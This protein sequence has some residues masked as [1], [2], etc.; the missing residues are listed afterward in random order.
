MRN[1]REY[2]KKLFGLFSVI[3]LLAASCAKD[4][5]YFDATVAD[6]TFQGTTYEYLKSKPGV[7]DSLVSVIDR[8]NLQETL[9]DSN[10]TLFAVTNPSFRLAITNLNNLRRST[11]KLP[12]YLYNVDSVQLDTMASQYIIKGSVTSDQL[13]L[14]DGL[15][16]ESVRTFYPMH[17]KLAK[18]SS[19]GYVDGGPGVIEFSNTNKSKFVRDWVTTSTTANNIKTSNGLIHVISPDHIFGFDQFVSRI[20][21][22]PPPPNL[23][24][25]VGGTLSVSSESSGGPN[26]P[27]ASRRVIDRD[28]FSKFFKGGFEGGW[29][30]FEFKQ[31]VVAGS[32]TITSANDFEGRDPKAWVVEG[33]NDNSAWEFLDSRRDEMFID[34]YMERVF[35]FNNKKAYKFYRITFTTMRSGIDFQIAEWSMNMP[36]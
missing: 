29:L 18:S 3:T 13:S 7:F 35:Y 16:L 11:D 30:K 32:Y 20:T 34:R 14:Q 21:Y 2:M 28:R 23:F 27:E 15:G 5:G 25:L 12:Q 26:G 1:S 6:K 9:N 31:P 19:S 36:K 24:I 17:G 4:G 8:L 33:S 10:V 22:T